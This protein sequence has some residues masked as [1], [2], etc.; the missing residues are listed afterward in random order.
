MISRR[1]RH[2]GRS[3]GYILLEAVVSMAVLSVSVV[4]I[5]ASLK[6]AILVKGEA[7]DYTQARFILE[8]QIAKVEIQDP[9]TEVENSGRCEGDLSRFRWRYKVT[10][11]ALPQPEMPA[12]PVEG[13]QPPKMS[14]PYMAKI[15]VTATWSRAGVEH[16]ETIETLWI[17]EKLWTPPADP[18]RPPGD[19]G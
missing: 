2:N 14:A 11:I 5:N 19:A 9:L 4:G 18:L 1:P 3:G 6:Q 13:R 15:E 7:Q 8:E 16:K 12:A 17:P 10:K